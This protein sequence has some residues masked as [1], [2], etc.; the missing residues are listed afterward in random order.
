VSKAN[1]TKDQSNPIGYFG[2][3]KRFRRQFLQ[4]ANE[5]AGMVGWRWFENAAEPAPQIFT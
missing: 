5:R 1:P 2:P 3:G 4:I